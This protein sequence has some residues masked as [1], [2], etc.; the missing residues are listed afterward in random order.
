MNQTRGTRWALG[1]MAAGAV[2]FAALVG[3]AGAAGRSKPAGAAGDPCASD[4]PRPGPGFLDPFRPPSAK[5]VELNAA[6]K[7]P[8]R[9]GKWDEARA[10]YRAAEA[11]DPD[12][13]AP[14]LN[15]ACSF[16]RQERFAEATA[17]V[18]ALL[19][20][21]YVPWS[22]EVL[23]AADL[24]ALKVRP[25]MNEVRRALAASAARWGQ[26]LDVSAVFVARQRPPLRVPDGPGVFILNPHQ[27]VWAYTPRTQRY[28][29]LTAEDGH[30]VALAQTPD[31][32]R[33]LYVTAEKLVRGARP[34][35]QALRGVTL[36]EL[37]LATMGQGP[38]VRVDGDVRRLEIRLGRGEFI[39]ALAGDKTN[40]LFE[41]TGAGG[42]SPLS[43][44]AIAGG[45]SLVI[46][47][48]HGAVAIA[49]ARAGV[50]S[51]CSAALRDDK[52]QGSSPTVKLALRAGASPIVLKPKEGAGRAGLPIP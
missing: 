49:G 37:A 33:V 38:A 48:A 2:A 28:R 17:E 31:A 29:Q 1:G 25:E 9:L 45:L 23:E 26:D 32:R 46:L 18:V 52:G 27:E 42:L 12:F 4:G 30:V 5:A 6:G 21:A 40:G 7:V 10:Q 47:T 39:V 20:R 36:H 11:A 14:K 13:L 15:V 44:R 16:V 19:E 50:G 24:G 51:G 41:T 22:R 43:E 3:G 35:E 34:D 8:Y